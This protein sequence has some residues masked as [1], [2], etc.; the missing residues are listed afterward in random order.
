MARRASDH[1]AIEAGARAG[2]VASGV[3]H[4]VI[5]WLAVKLVL[6]DSAQSTDQ[7]GALRQLATTPAGSGLL[8]AVLAG[9]VLLGLWN[10]TEAVAR[11]G[12]AR[13]KP[14]AKVVVY[15]ALAVT[16]WSVLH[17]SS[18]GAGQTQGATAT[19]MTTSFGVLLVGAIGLAVLGV[20]IYHVAKGA[21]ATFL[22][23]LRQH[24]DVWVVRL[25]RLGYVAKGVALGIVGV[26]FLVAAAT[27][28]PG[29]AGGLDAA[30]HALLGVPAGGVFVS[31]VAL[32]F[33]CFGVYS[34]ARAR[35]AKV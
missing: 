12:K 18:S 34:F 17:G 26:L 29:K 30:L 35:Y 15:A 1:P 10:V 22:R 21:R 24:P 23:D 7:T 2:Y 13:A 14:A 5:A 6:G 8:W 32:G 28:D 19:L 11:S 31:L 25:G 33:A 16:A 4:L 20:G 9:F 3:L 27:H